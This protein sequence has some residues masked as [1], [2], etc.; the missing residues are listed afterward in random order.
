MCARQGASVF[1]FY[2]LHSPDG[3]VEVDDRDLRSRAFFAVFD[4]QE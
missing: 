4:Y 1:M 2:P 3:I